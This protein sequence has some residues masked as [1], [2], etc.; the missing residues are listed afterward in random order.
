MYVAKKTALGAVGG[1]KFKLVRNTGKY[2]KFVKKV[3]KGTGKLGRKGKQARLRELANDD[4]LSSALRGEIQRDIN[5][6]KRGKRKKY[7][8]SKRI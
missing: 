7:K 6:I 8:S 5:E 4:K 2:V 3:T 1:G